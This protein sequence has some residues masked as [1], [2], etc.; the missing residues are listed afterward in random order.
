[1]SDGNAG[2]SARNGGVLLWFRRDLRLADLPALSEGLAQGGPIWPVYIWD[3]VAASE[4]GAA[5]R[6]RLEQSLRA[7][8]ADIAARGGRLIVRRGDALAQLRALI[9]E[10]GASTVCWTRL[11]TPQA[12]ARDKQVKAAL[13]SDGVKAL[14][15][16][17]A[18]LIEPWEVATKSGGPFRVFSPFWR[19]LQR[20]F[21]PDTGAR[22]PSAWPAGTAAPE[23]LRVEE[24]GLAKDMRR[25][26]AIVV[27]FNDAGEA[28]AAAQLEQFIGERLRGYAV[29]R[30]RLDHN[31]TSGLS[32]ALTLGEISPHRIWRAAQAA[33]AADPELEKDGAHF[34]SEVGWRDFAWHLGYHSPELFD[35][36]WR[37][38]WD[39]FP[40]RDDNEE[41]ERWRRGLT[42]E[43]LVDAAMRELYVTGRMHNRARMLVASYLTKHLMT[44][45]R[46]GAA[47][48]REC[49]VDYDP[50]SNAMGWQWT[51]GSGPDA[52]PFFR[53]FNPRG[54]AEKFDPQGRYLQRWLPER[55][56]DDLLLAAADQAA[57]PGRM[58][59][60]ACPRFWGLAAG[61]K[62][63]NPII[64]LS[65]GR[66]RAMAAYHQLKQAE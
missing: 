59:F 52:A 40:W 19:A 13:A 4:T 17:G 22:A 65:A 51:A 62:R 43:P 20:Q 41:A 63:P 26:A 15:H 57:S 9:N 50:A 47:W 42:G 18:S 54:Q 32:P 31:G 33:M 61:K 53:I 14:S 16:P 6:W 11:Y 21:R 1:M 46:V 28:A 23:S 3:D 37:P 7:L 27:R 49:L 60:E 29:Q 45:W 34:L 56:A 12:I 8:A 44:D 55:A 48:F 64:D 24:L 39:A 25:G 5:S 36:N 35:R 30:N 2:D 10:T 66:Q 58:F 38:E